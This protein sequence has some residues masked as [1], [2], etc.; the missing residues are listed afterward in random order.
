MVVFLCVFVPVSITMIKI[1]V[2]A[3]L[4]EPLFLGLDMHIKLAGL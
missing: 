3:G 1:L 4:K 2:N